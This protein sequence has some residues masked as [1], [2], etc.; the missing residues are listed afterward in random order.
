MLVSESGSNEAPFKHILVSVGER[1]AVQSKDRT[2][3]NV[4]VKTNRMPSTTWNPKQ[5]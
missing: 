5:D 1:T 2:S 4:N 3:G